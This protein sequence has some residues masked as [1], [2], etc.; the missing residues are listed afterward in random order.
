MLQSLSNPFSFDCSSFISTQPILPPA[1]DI[2][3]GLSF[4]LSPGCD[5]FLLFWGRAG[6]CW[7]MS[8]FPLDLSLWKEQDLIPAGSWCQDSLPDKELMVCPRQ[9]CGMD[10]RDP[11]L[12]PRQLEQLYPQK[13]A[14]KSPWAEFGMFP[15]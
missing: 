6:C 13:G 14:A 2:L 5:P 10:S 3:M 15:H 11:K 7:P 1:D 8:D 9:R 4:V 12:F